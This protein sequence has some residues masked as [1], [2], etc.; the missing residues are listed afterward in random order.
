VNLVDV[1]RK[2]EG[3]T[4]EYKRDL[5]SPDGLLNTLVAFANTAG[6]ILAIGIEDKTRRVAGIPDVL[7]VEE[8]LAS[9]IADSIKPRLVP[10][11]EVVPW[12]KTQVL[13]V[14]VYPSPS[15]PHYL[16]RLGPEA[17][18]YVRLGSTNRRADTA[19]IDEMRRFGQFESFDEQPIPDSNSE[20]LDFRVASELFAP[21]RKLMPSAFRNLRVTTELHGRD[22]PTV[23]GYLL[24]ARNRFDRFPDAWLQAGRFAGRD[25]AKILDSSE[26]RSYLPQAADYAIAFA[27]KHL[28]R[29]AVITGAHRIDRW[30]V[31]MIALRE[32]IINAIVHASYAEKGAPIRVAVFADRIEVENPGILPFG[33]TIED[34]RRGVSRLRNRVIGRVFH[35]LG[36]IEQWGSGIQRMTAA[37]EDAGLSPPILEEI[38]THFRVTLAAIQTR[39]IRTDPV[40][41]QILRLLED[42]RG[43]STAEIAEAISLSARATRTR[44]SDLVSRGLI[45]EVG[46]GLKDPRRQYFRAEK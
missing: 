12:R 24:F 11:I 10:D 32:A 38:G 4:L 7:D 8:R 2:P 40:D 33:L 43:R 25:R 39:P 42:R 41:Q 13:I 3:K 30:T 29:E 18:V 20:V 36:L 21:I 26:I 16:E 35:E 9:L 15:R 17:G 23:G 22:V 34:I 5:S 14:Q 44:L 28:S 45:V 19:Q 27:Q 37:C 31:P 1:L 6:G 46:S